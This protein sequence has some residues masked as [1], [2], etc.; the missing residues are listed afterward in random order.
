MSRRLPCHHPAAPAAA[1]AAAADEDVADGAGI[2]EVGELGDGQGSGRRAMK[3]PRGHHRDALVGD[4]AKADWAEP[5]TSAHVS[6]SVWASSQAA[7]SGSPFDEGRAEARARRA[8]AG[9]ACSRSRVEPPGW[10]GLAQRPTPSVTRAGRRGPGRHQAARP[11][12]G[13]G[14]QAVEHGGEGGAGGS[15]T[16]GWP[17]VQP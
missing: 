15:G 5:T 12:R 9:P 8:L 16:A 6:P 1:H 4:E 10:D 13:Q 2:D 3:P 7:S 11:G 14:E 17:R